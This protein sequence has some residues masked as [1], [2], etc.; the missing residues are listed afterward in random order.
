MMAAGRRMDRHIVAAALGNSYGGEAGGTTIA[1]PSAQKI[2]SA[3]SGLTVAK[4]ISAKEI[5]GVG[6]VDEEAGLTAAINPAGLTDLLSSTQ[7]TSSD[8]NT[9]KALAMGQLDTFMGYKF[10]KSNLV[11]AGKAIIWQKNSIGIAVISEPFVRISERPD[12]NYSWQVF[13]EMDMGA[14]RVEEAGVVEISYV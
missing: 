13:I 14:T 3:S 7:I 10:I 11:T 6:D 12:K 4:L 9:V 5:L 2:A 1:L 8:Y